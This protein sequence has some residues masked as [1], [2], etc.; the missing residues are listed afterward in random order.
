MKWIEVI[1]LRS[2]GTNQGTVESK[3][4]RL[5][6]MDREKGNQRVVQVYCRVRVESDFCIHLVHDSKKVEPSGSHLALRL[7]SALKEFGLVNHGVWVAL[8]EEFD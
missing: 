7:V 2:T 5:I 4:R 1:L 3:L 8:D 6:K